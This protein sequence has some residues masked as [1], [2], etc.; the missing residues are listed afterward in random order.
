MVVSL[1]TEVRYA[2]DPAGNTRYAVPVMLM[3][4]LLLRCRSEV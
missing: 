3:R 1:G 2:E 4:S